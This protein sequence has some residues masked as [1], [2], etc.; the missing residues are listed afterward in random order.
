MRE[1]TTTCFAASTF[2]LSSGRRRAHVREG[3]EPG[4]PNSSYHQWLGRAMGRKAE[5][6]NPFTA[7]NLARKV[8]IEFERAVTLD[9]NNLSARS[10]LSEFYLEAPGLSGRHRTKRS[11]RQ[12]MW[13][14]MIARWPAIL[15]ARSGK[16]GQYRRGSGIQKSDCREQPARALLGEL[17][18]FYRRTGRMEKWKMLFAARWAQS[19]RE[20]PASLTQPR[21]WCI[22]DVTL[23]AQRRCCGITF[24]RK[25]LPRTGRLP[26]LL[27]AGR[28]AGK[29]GQKDRSCGRVPDRAEYGLRVPP[30]AGCAGARFPIE[31]RLSTPIRTNS[32]R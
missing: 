21:Y 16:A 24:L 7:F 10:D 9:G 1:P 25:M 28:G 11:S 26:R 15:C 6:A 18:H 22:Q 30:G 4:A 32:R 2:S 29:A 3:S 17:A 14:S 5:A 8:K 19:T 20:S 23:P 27:P 13:R 31:S 12:T